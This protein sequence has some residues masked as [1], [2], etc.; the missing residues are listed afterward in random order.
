MNYSTYVND[1]EPRL[2]KIFI[3]EII[4]NFIDIIKNY[5]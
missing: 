4:T 5:K 3:V 2:S 1:V